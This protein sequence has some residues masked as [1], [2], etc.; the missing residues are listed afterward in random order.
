[1][2]EDENPVG[3]RGSK[4]V[5]EP[6]LMYGIGV[7]FAIRKAMRAFKERD[8]AFDSPATPEKVLLG[9]QGDHL[10]NGEDSSLIP[11]VT[12][13]RDGQPATNGHPSPSEPTPDPSK[14]DLVD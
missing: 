2:R 3:P 4:A 8:Y 1:M 13:D 5:G 9:I 14:E 7:Y 6:P 11:D 10:E 12:V